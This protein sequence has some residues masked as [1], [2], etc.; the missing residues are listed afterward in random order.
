MYLVLFLKSGATQGTRMEYATRER[1]GWLSFKTI[2]WMV[3]GFG[4]QNP[5][6]VLAGI[7]GGTWR[8]RGV[9]IETKLS[10]EERVAVGYFYLRLDHNALGIQ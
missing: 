5:D 6:V 7:G 2:R 8:H 1:F 4:T 9:R 10:H 3:F